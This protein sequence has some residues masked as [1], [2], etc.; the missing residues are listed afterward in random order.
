[1]GHR[2]HAPR[3]D[4]N[5]SHHPAAL[6]PQRGDQ[7]GKRLSKALRTSTVFAWHSCLMGVASRP[8]AAISSVVI[9]KMILARRQPMAC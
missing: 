5:V 2:N 3:G 1:M 9:V 7:G 8:A 6:D 4:R